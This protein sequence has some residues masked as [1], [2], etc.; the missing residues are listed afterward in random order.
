MKYIR[1]TLIT[2]VAAWLEVSFLASWRPLGVIP[3]LFLIVIIAVASSKTRISEVM[4]MATCGGFLLDYVSGSDF[5]LRTAFFCFLAILM[6]IIRRTGADFETMGLK[7]AAVV[8]ATILYDVIILIPVVWHKSFIIWSVVFQRVGLELVLNFLLLGA[9][10]WPLRWLFDIDVVVQP[11]IG[12]E[13][14]S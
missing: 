6:V 1:L 13:H 14:H 2:F 5:G 4:A 3:D 11:V 7:L 12:G 10:Y 8:S 9:L